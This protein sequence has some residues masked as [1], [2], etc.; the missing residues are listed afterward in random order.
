[1]RISNIIHISSTSGVDFDI[2]QRLSQ[3]MNYSIVLCQP[4][5]SHDISKIT[6][7]KDYNVLL[8]NLT[9]GERIIKPKRQRMKIIIDC[10][11]SV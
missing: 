2:L 9:E 7:I 10:R 4:Y 3:K 5:N 1:M 6:S 8:E 11:K